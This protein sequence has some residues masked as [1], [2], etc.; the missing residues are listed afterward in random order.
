MQTVQI[1]CILVIENNDRKEKL[2][3]Y[4]SKVC[5]SKSLYLQRILAYV[6]VYIFTYAH[7]TIK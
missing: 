7:F 2:L 6:K 3:Y 5:V 1:S 4:Q